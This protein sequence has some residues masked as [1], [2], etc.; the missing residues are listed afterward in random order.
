MKINTVYMNRNKHIL[1]ILLSA[2]LMFTLMIPAAAFAA[3]VT[4]TEDA[5]ADASVNITTEYRYADGETPQIPDTITQNGVE[6]HLISQAEPVLESTLP[7]TRTYRHRINGALSKKDFEALAD[8]NINVTPVEVEKEREVD[9]TAVIKG[10]PNNDVDYM[11]ASKK[12][13]A[14]Y[15]GLEDAVAGVTYKVTDYDKTDK[16]PSSYDATVVFRGLEKYKEVGY[17]LADVSFTTTATEGQQSQYVIIATYAPPEEVVAEPLE[18]EAD[19]P[20]SPTD[21]DI[22]V[23]TAENPEPNAEADTRLED[24]TGNIFTDIVNGNVP[25][26]GFAIEDAWSLLSLFF[27]LIAVVI[28]ILLI[29]WLVAKRRIEGAVE[30]YNNGLGPVR[31]TPA[32]AILRVLTIVF[33]V[34]TALTWILLEDLTLHLVWVNKWTLF[35]GALF[36]IQIVLLVVYKRKN[37][38]NEQVIDAAYDN[39]AA[40]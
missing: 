11:I 30:N 8:Q 4:E 1:V 21:T 9:K 26:G 3:P 5:D 35:V 2:I 33:G 25:R 14:K 6:Y 34:L 13:T 29:I 37:A 36:I 38:K 40:S 24:Q 17:Y 39:S 31:K 18:P 27:A 28:S 19:E 16:L 12:F 10:L 7:L 15:A 22:N 32:A 23:A 20:E